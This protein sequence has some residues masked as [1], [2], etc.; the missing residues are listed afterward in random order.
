MKIL[1]LEKETPNTT[2]EQFAPYR[3]TT[4]GQTH[5]VSLQGTMNRPSLLQLC[6]KYQ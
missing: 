5:R 3:K 2:P 6:V 1:A 4:L